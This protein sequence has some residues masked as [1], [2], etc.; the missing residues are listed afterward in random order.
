MKCRLA[1]PQ[2]AC[3]LAC[4]L[5]INCLFGCLRTHLFSCI[6]RYSLLVLY[7]LLYLPLSSLV[8]MHSA[9]ENHH[10]RGLCFSFHRLELSA[11]HPHSGCQSSGCLPD[12][13]PACLLAC[14]LVVSA[15]T[16]CVHII[17]Y[18]SLL[19]FDFTASWRN[20]QQ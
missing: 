9:K 4:S 14:L 2:P 5:A 15:N 16:A 20:T 7:L 8:M 13:L 18:H 12:C 6:C 1:S 10:L 17:Y 19:T 3:S 11:C